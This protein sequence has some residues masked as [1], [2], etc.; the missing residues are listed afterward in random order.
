[1]RLSLS[2]PSSLEA[3]YRI[4]ILRNR[5]KSILSLPYKIMDVNVFFGK[6]WESMGFYG[7]LKI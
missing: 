6:T 2:P 7:K 1:M 3:F 4:N 5:D